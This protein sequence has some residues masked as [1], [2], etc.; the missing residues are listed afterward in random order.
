MTDT[1]KQGLQ[2]CRA[3]AECTLCPYFDNTSTCYEVL[4]TETLQRI[5][6]QE[7]TIGV[8]MELNQKLAQE[9][10]NSLDLSKGGT[11]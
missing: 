2:H 8:L 4:H 10:Q 1:V 6:Q 11:G 5:T 7:Q 9:L 3:G